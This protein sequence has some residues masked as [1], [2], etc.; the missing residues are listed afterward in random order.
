MILDEISAVV[1]KVSRVEICLFEHL[2][3]EIARNS[4]GQL[5]VLSIGRDNLFRHA[6]DSIVCY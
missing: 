2:D 3:F 4:L 5:W 1:A 6:T